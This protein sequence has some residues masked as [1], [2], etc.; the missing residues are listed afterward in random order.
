MLGIE[1]FIA[2]P[3]RAR[4]DQGRAKEE[5]RYVVAFFE[6]GHDESLLN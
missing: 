3:G 6:G 1:L 2:V 5:R 4:Y